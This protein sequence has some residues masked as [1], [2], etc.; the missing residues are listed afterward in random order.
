MDPSALLPVPDVLPA[1]WPIFEVLEL[2]LFTIHILLINIILGSTVVFLFSKKGV[3][4]DSAGFREKVAE[5][6]PTIFAFAVT[7][8]IAPLLFVQVVYGHLFYSSSVL[9]AWWWIAIVPILILVYGSLYLRA[10]SPKFARV[11]MIAAVVG[12]LYV[13]LMYANNFSMMQVPASWQAFFS[14]RGGT[15]LNFAD[16]TVFPRYFHFVTA[17]V[18]VGGL[19]LSWLA[20]RRGDSM[21]EVH[22][23][24]NLYAYATIAQMIIGFW[25]LIALPR[26]I[27]FHFMGER[28]VHTILL[29]LGILLA[30]GSLV[31]ALRH[32]VRPTITQFLLLLVTMT[33]MRAL[34]RGSYIGDFFKPGDMELVP[35]Y[36]V[37]VLFLVVLVIGLVAIGWMLK[38]VRAA[39]A[40]GTK[41]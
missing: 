6:L 21:S 23:G 13:G 1:P 29:M 8:G 14:N 3:Q 19:F 35:Q 28:I 34:L 27:M 40:G 5:K 17:S 30:I 12:F 18:A 39:Q 4:L 31:T 37:F 38:A 32:K 11:G 26:D 33:V 15:H 2:L 9:M 22:R 7:I 25:W 36:G 16:G 10:R 41:A 24:L 20:S